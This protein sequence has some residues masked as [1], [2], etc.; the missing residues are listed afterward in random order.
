MVTGGGGAERER[1]FYFIHKYFL[2]VLASERRKK[3]GKE[4]KKEK[5]KGKKQQMS[6]MSNLI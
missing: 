4:R 3:R 1:C 2:R 6:E 5:K